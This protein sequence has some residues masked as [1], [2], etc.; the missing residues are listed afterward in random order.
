[1]TKRPDPEVGPSWRELRAAIAA[2]LRPWVI[3]HKVDELAVEIVAELVAAPGWRP[4]LEPAPEVLV[5]DRRTR[6]TKALTTTGGDE[7]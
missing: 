5:A 4:P 7:Q 1:M 2:K 3:A 6:Y